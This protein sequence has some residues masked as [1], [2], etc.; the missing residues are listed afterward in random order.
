MNYKDCRTHRPKALD[1]DV[2]LCASAP[3]HAD[4]DGIPAGFGPKPARVLAPLVGVDDLWGAESRNRLSQCLDRLRCVKC[5]AQPP[6]HD[7]TAEDV[8]DGHQVHVSLGH[9]DIGDVYRPHLV[10]T[11]DLQVAQQ[12]RLDVGRLARLGQRPDR[13]DG[14]NAH[15]PHQPSHALQVDVQA[16]VHQVQLYRPC[17]RSGMFHI[18][19]VHFLH[20]FF[21][22]RSFALGLVVDGVAADAQKLA[23]LPY[24]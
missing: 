9:R 13:I 17:A 3:I 1:P 16:L 12:V 14:V 15:L 23:L 18:E 5:V 19:P 22:L 4:F 11:R 10:G 21:V 8:Y 7:A 6:R 2:I 24:A 20:R